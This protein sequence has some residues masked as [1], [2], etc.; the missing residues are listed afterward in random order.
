MTSLDKDSI[1]RLRKER[2]HIGYGFCLTQTQLDAL[3]ASW[4][5]LVQP[6]EK[7]RSESFA[8]ARPDGS[9]T[10]ATGPRWLFH[11]LGLCHRAAHV[12]F[13]TPNGLIV[14]QRRAPTKADWPDAW[15]MA[16]AGHVPQKDDGSDM[17]F[18]EGALKEIEEELGLPAADL[19]RLLVEG[20]LT[21]VGTPYFSFE[22]DEARNPPFFNAESRQIFAATLNADGLAAL[23]PDYEELSGVYFCPP[24]EAW[25]LLVREQI[26][27]GLR[28]SLPRYLSWL[29][30]E[31]RQV[32]SSGKRSRAG[33]QAQPRSVD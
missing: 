13:R 19:P 22:M 8:I 18:E 1:R 24:E 26:A 15:D 32:D 6:D 20:G 2:Q 16:V 33:C 9:T 12:G 29:R 30:V 31:Q 7:D 4:E 11:L 25:D 10:G 5:P 14:L 27:G 28:Y 3:R 23:R 21:A 17:S